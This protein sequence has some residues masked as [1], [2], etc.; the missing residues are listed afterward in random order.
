MLT[1]TVDST[2]LGQYK[3]AEEG[4]FSNNQARLGF[5]WKINCSF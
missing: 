2:W 5:S 1:A 3:Q 4:G